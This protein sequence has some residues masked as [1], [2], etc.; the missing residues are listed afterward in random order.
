MSSNFESVSPVFRMIRVI[1]S[2]ASLAACQELNVHVVESSQPAS[3]FLALREQAVKNLRS[4]RE[5]NT[6]VQEIPGIASGIRAQ[7]EPSAEFH[8]FAPQ[9]DK[10]NILRSIEATKRIHEELQK[11]SMEHLLA[12]FQ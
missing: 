12:S 9:E 6:F 3:N 2:L 4:M 1:T 5:R 7:I 10:E 11:A 8:L